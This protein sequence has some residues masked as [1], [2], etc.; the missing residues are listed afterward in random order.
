[1]LVV[2]GA[3]ERMLDM[4]EVAI[5]AAWRGAAFT[6]AAGVGKLPDLEKVAVRRPRG[7]GGPLDEAFTTAEARRWEA[8]AKA[9]AEAEGV[10]RG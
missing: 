4:L 3:G 8:I 10:G 7:A 5:T 9:K 1:M 6:A 2:R